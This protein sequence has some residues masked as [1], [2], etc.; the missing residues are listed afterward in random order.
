MQL[1]FKIF[2]QFEM[3]NQFGLLKFIGSRANRLLLE[4]PGTTDQFN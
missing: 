2:Q 4:Q 3:C 1:Q